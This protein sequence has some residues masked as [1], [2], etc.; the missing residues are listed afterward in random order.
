MKIYIYIYMGFAMFSS[1]RP[2]HYGGKK[3]LTEEMW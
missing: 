2:T 3:P 1:L